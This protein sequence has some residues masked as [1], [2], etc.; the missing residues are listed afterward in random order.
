MSAALDMVGDVPVFVPC[1]AD[2]MF[3]VLTEPEAE[4]VGEAVVFLWGAGALPSFGKNLILARLARAAA[5]AGYHA[6]RFDYPGSG[7]STGSVSTHRLDDLGVSEVEAVCGWLEDRG[8]SRF[9]LVGSCSGARMALASAARVPGVAAIAML[10]PP[11]MDYTREE[12]Q[13]RKRALESRTEPEWASARFLGPLE[14]ALERGLPVLLLYGKADKL[15]REFERARRGPLGRLLEHA[16]SLVSVAAFDGWVHADPSVEGQDW[17]V[18]ALGEWLSEL[19][20][21]STSATVV[22]G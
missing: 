2:D 6:L 5:A 10:S 14:E 15:Y 19:A 17:V 7:D 21:T 20:A 8:L 9:A 18:G 3:G 22:R 13:A 11:V 1:G 16:G 12:A 4:P